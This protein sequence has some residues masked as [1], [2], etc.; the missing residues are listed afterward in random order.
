M[1][2]FLFNIIKA[3][4]LDLS[5]ELSERGYISKNYAQISMEITIV[6]TS[7]KLSSVIYVQIVTML[8]I[9]LSDGP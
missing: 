5:I 3:I 7:V 6:I 1:A 2:L 9:I 4:L 8:T